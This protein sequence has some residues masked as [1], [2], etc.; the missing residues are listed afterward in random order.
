MVK[1]NVVKGNVSSVGKLEVQ[2]PDGLQFIEEEAVAGA[3]VRYNAGLLKFLWETLPS[4][5]QFEVTFKLKASATESGI[6]TLSGTLAYREEDQT[7]IEQLPTTNI[8]IVV[9]R[10][11]EETVRIEADNSGVAATDVRSAPVK[12]AAVLEEKSEHNVD[13]PVKALADKKET[14]AKVVPMKE[15]M[16][17]ALFHVQIMSS[18]SLVSSED[19]RNRFKTER[20]IVAIEHNDGYKYAIG[21]LRDYDLAKTLCSDVRASGEFPGCFV[22]SSF[23][24]KHIPLKAAIKM[25]R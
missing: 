9:V 1:I 15:D 19:L 10:K 3:T 17:T 2:I 24:G 13:E 5:N 6:N 14:V 22:I 12:D 21:S 8:E 4:D 7:K 20:E 16:S 25:N 23:N 11:K 18:S